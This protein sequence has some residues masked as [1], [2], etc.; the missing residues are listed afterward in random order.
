MSLLNK[1]YTLFLIFIRISR[2]IQ[3]NFR[4]VTISQ[5]AKRNTAHNSQWKEIL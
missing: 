1:Y 2:L 5:A 4:N 3:S